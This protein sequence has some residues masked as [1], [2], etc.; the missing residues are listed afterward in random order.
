MPKPKTRGL[1]NV[2]VYPGAD[3]AATTLISSLSPDNTPRAPRVRVEYSDPVKK[4]EGRSCTTVSHSRTACDGKLEPPGWN[5][6][7]QRRT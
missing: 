1:Q 6:W 7:K 4:T 3:E 5:S 2:L